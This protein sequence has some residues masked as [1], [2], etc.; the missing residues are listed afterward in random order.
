MY[1]GIVAKTRL[2][3]GVISV[4]MF[5]LQLVVIKLLIGSMLLE[6]E[7]STE[8]VRMASATMPQCGWRLVL[9]G[10]HS[11]G[12]KLF[13]RIILFKPGDSAELG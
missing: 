4:V 6:Q 10:P 5:G 12:T 2:Q 11:F 1:I 9:L 3:S 7:N 8:F 13:V